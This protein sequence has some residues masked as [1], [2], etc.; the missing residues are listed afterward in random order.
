MKNVLLIDIC[1][2]K[3]GFYEFV[4]PVGDVLIKNKVK[5]FVRS[6]DCLKKKDLERCDGVIICGTTLY[7]GEFFDSV[8]KFKWL[9]EFDKP[10]LG[11]CGGM[12]LIGLVFGGKLKKKN[13]IGYFKEDF[14]KNFLGLRG[15]NEVYHLHNN[16]VDFSGLDFDV[17]SG[18]KVS[19][20]VKHRKKNIFG[21]LFHPEV[22]NKDLI[23]QFSLL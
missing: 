6:Y 10:I 22:R 11:I 14:K 20:A 4:K 13:E 9:L 19:Q 2:E 8:E 5:G 1:K 15:L 7:D 18:D 17:F 23:R 3:L 16:Y 21:V 12:Q